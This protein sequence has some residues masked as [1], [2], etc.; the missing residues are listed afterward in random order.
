M[1]CIYCLFA[2]D[3]GEPRYVGKTTRQPERRWKEHVAR[4]LDKEEQGQLCDWMRDILRRGALIQFW[5]L[6]EDVAPVDLDTFEAYWTRQF[7]NL[8]ND[9][10]NGLDRATD[11]GEAITASIKEALKK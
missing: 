1:G 4:A 10:S 6:Q 3:E 2:S 11:L 8:L 5:V 7:G 9:C